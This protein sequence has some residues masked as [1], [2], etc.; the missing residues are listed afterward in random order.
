MTR[1]GMVID[2]RRCVG[3]DACN[4]ACR[5][6]NNVENGH[7]WANRIQRTAGT[8]PNVTYD[9][10]PTLCNHCSDAPCVEACP[11][12]PKAMF[13]TP[14]GI[15]MHSE[16]RCI[17]CQAC[18][19]A[20]PYGVIY[21][22]EW[23]EETHLEWR[24]ADAT[25]LTDKVGGNVIPYSNPD[26]GTTY[27]AIRRPEK[28][29]KCTFCHHR[30]TVGENPACV[31]ACPSDARIWGD[32]DDPQSDVSRLLRE[33]DHFVLQPEAGTSPNVFYIQAFDQKA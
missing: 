21:F 1:I 5:N 24:T 17:G 6:E 26:P 20:C 27:A 14:E 3:C 4:I 8:F 28:V 31:D 25:A 10:T 29:E 2:L 32:L 30:I 22:N 23:D 7:F 33:N 13:K 18:Q 16:E 15:T 19:D 12:E 11:V 9:Y